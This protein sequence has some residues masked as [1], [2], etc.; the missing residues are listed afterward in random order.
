MVTVDLFDRIRLSLRDDEKIC[1]KIIGGS[2]TESI[3]TDER[4]LVVRALKA[5]R[6]FTG[7]SRPAGCD[8]L[9]HK[10][11][12]SAAGLG[13]ASSN[14]AAAL[15]AGIRLWNLQV[16]R[17]EMHAI[18]SRL[19]SDVPFFLYGSAALCRG[20]GE[21]VEPIE[22][23][24]RIPVVIAKPPSGLS[25]AAVFEHAKIQHPPVTAD[26]MLASV[27]VRDRRR[28]AE[29]MLNR[30]QSV[31]FELNPAIARIAQ[32]FERTPALGHQMSGS[33]SSY[34]GLFDSV[35]VARK[36]ARRLAAQLPE[37]TIYSSQTCSQPAGR[38]FDVHET[39]DNRT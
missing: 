27:A 33:G 12:P 28:I 9:L 11:I 37:A 19:G 13:G 5:L 2:D 29:S 20:R 34:F 1:L 10:R 23:V 18:A 14:A 8:V 32:L 30:L 36:T 16:P 4:N 38:P 21:I 39:V 24:G 6:D 22:S 17:S 7:D 25:T 26:S 15:Q 31:S 35:H 3:P